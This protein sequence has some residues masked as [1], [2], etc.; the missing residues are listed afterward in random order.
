MSRWTETL[1]VQLQN[2]MMQKL[3]SYDIGITN[4]DFLCCTATDFWNLV[5]FDTLQN[6]VHYW[7]CCL[8]FYTMSGAVH[9]L[10]IVYL[11]RKT[12]KFTKN[13]FYH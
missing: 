1:T 2:Y 6:T 5:W 3:V 13:Y 11:Q 12:I 4:T 8:H 7:N 10:R 9:E